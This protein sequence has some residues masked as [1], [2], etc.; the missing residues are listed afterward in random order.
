M[1]TPEVDEF[2]QC[3]GMIKQNCCSHTFAMSLMTS[4]TDCPVVAVLATACA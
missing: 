3:T 4:K 1:Q 2:E